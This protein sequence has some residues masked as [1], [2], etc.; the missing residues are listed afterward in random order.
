LLT[1]RGSVLP[2]R[3][4]AAPARQAHDCRDIGRAEG[5]RTVASIVRCWRADPAGCSAA[6]VAAWLIDALAGEEGV[7]LRF[8]DTD[9][10]ALDVAA[11]QLPDRVRD[12]LDRALAEPRF[13]GWKVLE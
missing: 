5:L 13:A 10:V 9:F 7:R 6:L 12:L 1:G 3:G 8:A 4:L 11:P 2:S